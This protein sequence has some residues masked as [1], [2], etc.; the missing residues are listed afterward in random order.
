LSIKKTTE[1]FKQELKEVHGD[2]FTV[3]GEY[4][5]SRNLVKVRCNVCHAEYEVIP[6]SLLV[7][8]GC[9]YCS[10]NVHLTKE[11]V[12]QEID[13]VYGPEIIKVVSEYKNNSTKLDLLDIKT[14]HI[15]KQARSHLLE[16]YTYKDSGINQITTWQ[17][18]RKL[19]THKK[20]KPKGIIQNTE[21]YAKELEK[22]Y[23]HRFKLLSE[24]TGARNK[25]KV[26][27]NNCDQDIEVLAGILLEYGSCRVCRG[28][29]KSKGESLIYALLQENCIPFE[30]Q[31]TIRVHGNKHVLYND[32]TLENPKLVIEFDGI[33]HYRKDY[34][35]YSDKAVKRDKLK[36]SWAETNG[37][38]MVRIKNLN[39]LEVLAELK[40]YLG[41]LK[42]PQRL[43]YGNYYL[44]V[45]DILKEL[46][47]LSDK[48]IKLKYGIT[49]NKLNAIKQLAK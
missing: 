49:Q 5:G 26:H 30:Y 24:Y 22:K 10:G 21:D 3:L 8:R 12:Q 6:Y 31:K 13:T 39:L 27:C 20:V 9:K 19:D 17:T 46:V 41:D 45:K 40:P 37:Y 16:G 4:T 15:F 29:T 35:W 48:D 42:I 47:Q 7:G 25:L 2:K 44:P 11:Q 32:F 28:F 43:Q 18:S 23:P 34:N 38:T 33:Q 36:D 14:G 1:E